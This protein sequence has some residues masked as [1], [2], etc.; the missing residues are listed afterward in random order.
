[1][2]EITCTAL[3]KRRIMKAIEAGMTA[4]GN[5]VCLFP[6]KASWCALKPDES[7]RNC[8]ETKIRWHVTDTK[9]KSGRKTIA[10]GEIGKKP[11]ECQRNWIK[12]FGLDPD[13]VCVLAWTPRLA[14][15]F[16]ETADEARTFR[17]LE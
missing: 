15:L 2:I 3:E 13:N 10:D 6:R 8:L 7:C 17:L 12:S 5:A 1:M 11:T 9:K 14:V 4:I 16:D